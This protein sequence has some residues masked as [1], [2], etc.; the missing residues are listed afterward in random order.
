MKSAGHDTLRDLPMPCRSG[1][2]RTGGLFV[3]NPST[4]A[5]EV[6]AG[7]LRQVRLARGAGGRG[8]RDRPAGGT[9]ALRREEYYDGNV[10]ATANLLLA[11]AGGSV[12]LVHAVAGGD[13]TWTG[14]PAG[15]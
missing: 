2:I 13:W 5:T 14:Q 7:D 6:V 9:K 12:R 11:M 3:P 15:E 1:R 10:R 8:D 4:G